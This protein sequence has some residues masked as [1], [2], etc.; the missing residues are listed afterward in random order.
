V[1]TP[2]GSAEVV[3]EVKVAQRS[4]DKR[5]TTIVQLLAG[6]NDEPFVRIAYTTDGVARR[7]P[8]TLKLGELQRVLESVAGLPGLAAAFRIGGGA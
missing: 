2:W 8:V 7:G 5:F 1:A 3:E 4:S 6:A